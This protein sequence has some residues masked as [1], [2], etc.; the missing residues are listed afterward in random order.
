MGSG[1]EATPRRLKL[2]RETLRDLAPTRADASEVRGA[3]DSTSGAKR[4][5]CLPDL[6]ENLA[7]ALP[8]T[9]LSYGCW[10]T[11]RFERTETGHEVHVDL[12]PNQ[13]TLEAHEISKQQAIARDPELAGKLEDI[14]RR[15]A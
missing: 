15:F 5:F 13:A 14:G 4:E 9:F 6:L 1:D 10:G 2:E 8:K 11:I 7:P 12:Q 3:D